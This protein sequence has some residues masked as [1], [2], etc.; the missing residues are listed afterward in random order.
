MLHKMKE[1]KRKKAVG[2]QYDPEVDRA[3]KVRVKGA[4]FIADKILDLARRYGIPIKQDEELVETLYA[5]DLEREIPTE[6]YRAVAEILAY[7]YRI[8]QEL[9]SK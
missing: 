8:G 4:G 7:I 6:L 3:P 1:K 9:K 5:L 2:L